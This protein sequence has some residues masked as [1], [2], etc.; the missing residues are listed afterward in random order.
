M[1]MLNN[2]MVKKKPLGGPILQ[3]VKKNTFGGRKL[4]IHISLDDLWEWP[5]NIETYCNV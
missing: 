1:A 3:R 5:R 4:Y 2:Q